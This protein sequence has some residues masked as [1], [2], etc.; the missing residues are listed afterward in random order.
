MFIPAWVVWILGI[1]LWL[2]ISAKLFFTTKGDYD[3][4]SPLYGIMVFFA[5]LAFILGKLL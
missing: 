5:G 3:F 1:A 2:A 4:V